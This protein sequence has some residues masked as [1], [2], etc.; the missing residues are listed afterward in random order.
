MVTRLVEIYSFY[1]CFIQEKED[2]LSVIRAKIGQ[3]NAATY[4]FSVTNLTEKYS[5]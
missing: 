1:Y 4:V 2:N 5:R 3:C